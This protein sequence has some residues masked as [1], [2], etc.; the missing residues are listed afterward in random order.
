MNSLP[1]QVPQINVVHPK[2][3]QRPLERHLRVLSRAANDNAL[4][5]VRV[6]HESKLGRKEDLVALASALEPTLSRMSW[7]DK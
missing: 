6:W 7:A 2:P 1:M 5:R 3:L 4:R